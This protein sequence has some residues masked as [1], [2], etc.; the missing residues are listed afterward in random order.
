MGTGLKL[1]RSKEHPDHWVGEDKHGALLLFPAKPRG[2]ASRTP[3]AGSRPEL[4]EVSP[5]LARGTKW[6]GALGGKARH[7]S[8]EPSSRVIG[9]R[10]TNVEAEM[11]RRAA[12]ARGLS[13]NDWTRQALNEIAERQAPAAAATESSPKGS[14]TKPKRPARSTTKRA[15]KTKP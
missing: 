14:S 4:E 7:P 1:F 9:I 2:W 6:P 12:E 8:G 15:T 3:Y 11:W 13:L 10:G 5:M